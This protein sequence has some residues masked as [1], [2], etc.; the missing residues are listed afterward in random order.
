M[1][2]TSCWRTET[3][4]TTQRKRAELLIWTSHVLLRSFTW[5]R[6]GFLKDAAGPSA[7]DRV[8]EA[9]TSGNL[10]FVLWLC[11]VFRRFHG[12][13][14]SSGFSLVW[15]RCWT[16]V[17]KLPESVRRFEESLK[18]VGSHQVNNQHCAIFSSES[19]LQLSES[20]PASWRVKLNCKVIKKQSLSPIFSWKLWKYEELVD[21][22]YRSINFVCSLHG[23]HF[24]TR[25]TEVIPTCGC[26]GRCCS[27]TVVLKGVRRKWKNLS[28][29]IVRS[30]LV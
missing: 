6:S 17:V 21:L 20:A 1:W 25:A 11:G 4:H 23:N 16:S 29:I 14:M 15:L 28:G 9:Q 7:L 10:T 12:S 8:L 24:I 26:R 5:G 2:S 18:V 13:F 19:Q 27:V 30:V 3:V 22:I